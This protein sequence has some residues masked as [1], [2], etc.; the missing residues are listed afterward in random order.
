M[1]NVGSGASGKT[2]IGAG[3][4]ASGTFADI[5]T[6][7]GLTAHGVVVAEGSGAFVATAAGTAGQV[8]QSGGASADPAYSTAT[9]PATSGT[10]ST[11]LRSDGTNFVNT[12]ATYPTTT[13][14]NQILYS[15]ASNA[16]GGI[17]TA[18]NSILSTN[19]S[20]VPSMGTSLLNDYTFTSATAETSRS[21]TVSNTDNT[22]TSSS[23]VFIASTGG[24]SAGDPYSRYAVGTTRSYASGIDTSDS[25]KY[26]INTDASGT[27]T[28][29]SGTNIY[30]MTSGGNRTLPLNSCV[31]ADLNS[32]VANATG[33]G[34][35]VG[36]VIFDVDTGNFFDQNSN[37]NTTT[38]LF[39]VPVTGRYLISAA[40][41]L[42][43]LTASHTSGYI[44]IGTPGFAQFMINTIAPGTIRS[45]ANEATVQITA[46]V[47]L[48][49]G[50]DYGISLMVAGG[51][52]V[53]GLKGNSFGSYSRL[54]INLIS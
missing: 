26:K 1:A 38:G 14:V 15:S 20:G 41:T 10:A 18:N 37:Y 12:T 50:N 27:T 7:S 17:T 24:T 46:I 4:G 5:G 45:S 42:Q 9:Y 11:L 3:N 32:T 19:A 6:N 31:S 54:S 13:T 34:T 28:P 29:S 16:V 49:A 40:V 51:T 47:S 2:F 21:V 35:V 44:S 23:A 22:N 30:T 8:L 39:T 43:D 33:D 25:Q 53:V 52:K 48:G 36:P